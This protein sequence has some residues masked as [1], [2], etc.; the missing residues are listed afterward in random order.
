[1]NT[2]CKKLVTSDITN[3]V[4]YVVARKQS[5][6]VLMPCPSLVE[7]LLTERVMPK[8]H[9]GQ[10]KKQTISPIFYILWS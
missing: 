6:K 7:R 2:C 10:L 4:I 5:T 1:M 3:K 8:D 9:I